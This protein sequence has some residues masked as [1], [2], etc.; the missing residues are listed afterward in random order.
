MFENKKKI[1]EIK[2]SKK[3]KDIDSFVYLINYITRLCISSES[4][5]FFILCGIRTKQE[6]ELL[7]CDKTACHLR[8]FFT[9]LC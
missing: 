5:L 7:P 8:Q 4:L 1:K 6:M 3:I 9:D 2:K